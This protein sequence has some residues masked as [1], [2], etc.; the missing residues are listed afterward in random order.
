M[1]TS[2]DGLYTYAISGSGDQRVAT[3]V[4]Q[5]PE[6]FLPVPRC[7]VLKD[8]PKHSS[9][10][11]AMKRLMTLLCTFAILPALVTFAG[12]KQEGPAERAG[13]QID[14]GVEK[15][16]EAMKAGAE[17]TEEAMEKGAKAVKEG[18]EKV[19]EATEKTV[20]KAKEATK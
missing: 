7:P 12:C 18:A 20:E 19:G 13:K 2:R 17:K 3:P 4:P 10:E 5:L 14:K 8:I 16:G 11:G 1:T 9:K 6:T 15:T